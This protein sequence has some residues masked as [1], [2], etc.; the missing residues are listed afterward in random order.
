MATNRKDLKSYVRYD[1]SGRVIPGSN[2]LRKNMPKVGNWKETQAY[3]CCDPFLTS[4]TTSTT[5]EAPLQA[6]R[7]T[8]DSIENADLL[9]GDS[10]DVNDWNTFFDL[11]TYGNPFTSVEVVGNEVRL[12]GGSEITIKDQLFDQPDGLGI[13]LIEVRDE[14]LCVVA[15][16]YDCFGYEDNIGCPNLTTAIFPAMLTAGNHCFDN[17]P[18]SLVNVDFSSL[19]IAGIKCFGSAAFVDPDFPVLSPILSDGLFSNCVNLTDSFSLL[20]RVT[21]TGNNCF[22]S[23][24]GFINLNLPLLTSAGD[25]CFANCTSLTTVDLPSLT[26]AGEGSFNSCISLTTVDLP[27]LT[28]AGIRCFA[29]CTSLTTVFLPQLITAENNCFE[30]C[31][32]LLSVNLPLLTNVNGIQCFVGCTSLTTINL[33]SCIQLGQSN[34][35]DAVFQLITGNTI[36]ATFNIALSTNIGGNPDGDIQY[37]E[38]NNVVTVTYV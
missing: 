8:F 11:P 38:S 9:V 33:P 2:V 37:L 31:T 5:T 24:T 35:Y 26:F 23:C 18:S 14:A 30:I 28:T 34:G 16:G 6:L 25:F 1:G 29:S 32:S 15:A 4:T 7:L 10:S 3:E 20:S 27:E 36:T 13:H 21:E 12:F 19:T 22:S 17:N